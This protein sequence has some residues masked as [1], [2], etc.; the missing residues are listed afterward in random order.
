MAIWVIASSIPLA[1]SAAFFVL[2]P[3]TDPLSQRILVSAHGASITLLC[4]VAFLVGTFGNPRQEFREPFMWSFLVPLILIG[5]SLFAF[6]GKKRLLFL[7][8]I[9]FAW[10]F[11]AFTIGSMAITGVWA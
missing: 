3:A 7:H 9:N 8:I 5:L 4:L 6:N 10:L 1:I 2:S 11:V